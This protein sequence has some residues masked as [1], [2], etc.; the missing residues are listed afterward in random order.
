MSLY[1]YNYTPLKPGGNQEQMLS[2]LYKGRWQN[3]E[4]NYKPLLD[5]LAKDVNS[6]T[7][8]QEASKQIGKLPEQ[9][10]SMS[11]RNQSRFAGGLTA[12]QRHQVTQTQDRLGGLAGASTLN[13]ARGLQRQRNE[14]LSGDLMQISEDMMTKGTANLTQFAANE[15]QRR[16]MAAEAKSSGLSQ[17][18][19]LGG[20]VVGGIFGGPMGASVGAS[21]GS[22]AG[23]FF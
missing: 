19:S 13:Q 10:A 15:Q 1:T 22:M 21:A 8:V 11:A 6:R 20:A 12:A 2:T 16:Q 5:N 4:Q 7:L 17:L 3:F 14:S 9:L 18:L 23:S